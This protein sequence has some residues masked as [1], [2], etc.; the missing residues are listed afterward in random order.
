LEIAEFESK[1]L[2]AQTELNGANIMMRKLAIGFAA[3]VIATGGATLSASAAYHGSGYHGGMTR[4]GGYTKGMYKPGY[5]QYGGK[6]HRPYYWRH[7]EPRY[8]YYRPGREY[9]EYGYGRYR[10]DYWRHRYGWRHGYYR[11]YGTYYG[12]RQYRYGGYKREY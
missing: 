2:G 8:G 7:H 9:G 3:A 12:E 4:H 6:Y 5:G 11:P 10:P 1:R